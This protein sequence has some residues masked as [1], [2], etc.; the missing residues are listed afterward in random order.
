M[1]GFKF[2]FI[3]LL[4]SGCLFQKHEG[5]ILHESDI[6]KIRIGQSKATVRQVIGTPSFAIIND[7]GNDEWFYVSSKKEWRAFF[8]PKTTEQNILQ[9]EF[10]NDFLLNINTKTEIPKQD[11][12]EPKTKIIPP[13][14]P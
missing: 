12:P 11:L 4:L 1:Q 8:K 6:Q 9:L 10:K 2:I 7:A 3:F 13:V 14:K 5:V